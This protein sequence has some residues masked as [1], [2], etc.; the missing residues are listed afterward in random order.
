MF[1]QIENIHLTVLQGII[2]FFIVGIPTAV[3]VVYLVKSLHTKPSPKD[4]QNESLKHYA[5]KEELKDHLKSDDAV[6]AQIFDKIDTKIEELRRQIYERINKMESDSQ[7]SRRRLHR[8]VDTVG[9]DVAAIKSFTQTNNDQ[10]QRLDDKLE[11]KTKNI[12]D[13]LDDLI[14]RMADL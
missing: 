8:D 13:K 11:E 10:I 4:V 9:K 2:A 12:Y 5:T 3:G 1:A 14:K 6:H 7:E